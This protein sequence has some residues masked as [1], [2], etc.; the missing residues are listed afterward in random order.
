MP[1][2]YDASRRGKLHPTGEPFG[3]H[4]N[5]PYTSNPISLT[6]SAYENDRPIVRLHRTQAI[7]YGVVLVVVNAYLLLLNPAIRLLLLLPLLLLFVL[8]HVRVPPSNNT[9]FFTYALC[10]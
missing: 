6:P 10:D 3:N 9:Y 8:S 1:D 5:L 7:I 2:I 4:Q